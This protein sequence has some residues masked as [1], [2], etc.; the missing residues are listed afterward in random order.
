MKT[1]Q[2]SFLADD[3]KSIHVHHW[4]PETEP[5]AGVLVAHGMAE[6]AAR[7][8]RFATALSGAGYEVWA[9]DHRGHGR[10]A[11]EGELGWLADRDGFRRVVEDLH[12]LSRRIAAEH[13]GRKLFLFGHSWGSFLSQGY[14]SLY[15][16]ELAGCVLSG[17]AG[18]G[19]LTVRAG[20][21]VAAIGCAAKGQRVKAPLL[22]T[23]SFGS[24]N[25]AFKPERTTFDWLSRDTAEVDKYIADPFC[26]F[27]CTYGFFR[28]LL[29]GLVWVHA[30]A[31]MAAIPKSLPLLMIAGSMDPVGAATG[32]FDW[33]LK[34]YRA[35][36]MIDLESK[37][38]PGGRHE[39]L[40]DT[41]RDEATAD[42]LAWLAARS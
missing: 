24:F 17:T 26:G 36:G 34:R 10:T 32:S 33:L 25:K 22:N 9:P 23:M 31:T 12:G 2:F 42:T 20:R 35:L 41:C 6:H 4:V 39:V 21:L 40:N 3:G 27:V 19:G 15:G 7:Y 30:P 37:L 38:Y 16:S 13:P 14:V 1:D 5:K 11:A 28:D 29:A 18:D 8:A